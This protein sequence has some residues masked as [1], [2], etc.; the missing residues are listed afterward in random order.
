MRP[1]VETATRRVADTRARLTDLTDSQVTAQE[2]EVAL[3]DGYAVAL[4]GDAWIMHA[5]QRF[6][7][8]VRHPSGTV[9]GRDVRTFGRELRAFAEDVAALRHE[10]ALLH[11]TQQRRHVNAP[12]V[13]A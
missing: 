3:G 7:E 4:E 12:R 8:L 10:L 2:I 5:D 13:R 11:E 9:S 6:A 1:D